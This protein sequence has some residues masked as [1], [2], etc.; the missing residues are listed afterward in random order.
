MQE[1]KKELN[2]DFH[3]VKVDVCVEENIKEAFEWVNNTFNSVDV[4]I[5]NA[6]VFKMGDL[7][8]NVPKILI[9]IYYFI[10]LRKTTI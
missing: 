7:L 6:G 4:L 9:V 8:G 10:K 2:D 1:L 3:Y 5:N